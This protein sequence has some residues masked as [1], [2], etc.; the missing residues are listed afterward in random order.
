M[1]ERTFGGSVVIVTGAGHGIGR[2][3]AVAFAEQGA[4]VVAADRDVAR[5]EGV[6]A[7]LRERFA[8]PALPIQCDVSDS[9]AVTAMVARTVAE[10]GRIDVLVNNAGV[11]PNTPVVE[12]S[13]DEWDAVFDTN[14]KGMFLVSRAVA[15]R[16]IDRGNGRPHRQHLLRRGESGRVG[17]AHYCASKAAVNMFTQ[18]AGAGAGAARHHGQ[19]GRDR[20]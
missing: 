4:A 16:M 14:V 6:A 18:S 20:G 5:A 10:L 13:E 11:Y 9:A 19:R 3:I 2:A 8:T 15:R 17:A 1:S 12:I 7:E